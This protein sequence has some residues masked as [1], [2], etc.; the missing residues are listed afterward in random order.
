MNYTIDPISLVD[1]FDFALSRAYGTCVEIVLYGVL[2][3]LLAI[4]S[5]V[6]YHRTAAGRRSLAAATFLM[7]VLATLQLGLRIR[8]DVLAFQILRLAIRCGEW[9]D[10]ARAPSAQNPYATLYIAEDFL[11]VTNNAIADSL[12]VDLP[13]FYDLGKELLG[14]LCAYGDDHVG[15]DSFIDSRVAFLMSVLTNIVL[16]V[17][18]A[19][20]ICWIRRDARVL[21]QTACVHRYSTAIAIILESGM[22]YCITVAAFLISISY[23]GAIKA[24]TLDVWTPYNFTPLTN[25][26]RGAVPQIMN[27][28]P[29][30][31]IVRVGIGHGVRGT[32]SDDGAQVGPRRPTANAAPTRAPSFVLDICA[33]NS[34]VE[35]GTDIA[36]IHVLQQT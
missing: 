12:F 4:A 32:A 15:S 6:L 17:L 36:P 34:D 9:P 24:S 18:T 30:L 35:L 7:A 28:A 25:I 13:L 19:S 14:Y 33:H 26:L 16:M 1:Y 3:V 22:I 8:A 10:F 2:L 23:P 11:L 20:R 31:I 21:L 27:V 29:I 5:Y